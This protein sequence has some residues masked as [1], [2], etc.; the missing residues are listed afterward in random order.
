MSSV[1]FP[2][3]SRN[4]SLILKKCSFYRVAKTFHGDKCLM[5]KVFSLVFEWKSKMLKLAQLLSRMLLTFILQHFEYLWDHPD[6]RTSKK[7][8]W[9]F[10]YSSLLGLFSKQF[11]CTIYFTSCFQRVLYKENLNCYVLGKY[12]WDKMFLFPDHYL[13]SLLD[14]QIH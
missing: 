8:Q 13:T 11:N 14:F 10:W 2:P 4:S 6:F 9:A 12:F 5:I 3:L 1:I 7:K